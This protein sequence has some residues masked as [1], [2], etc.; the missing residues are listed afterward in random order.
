MIKIIYIALRF[1][2]KHCLFL[3][4][5][6]DSLPMEKEKKNVTLC[7]HRRWKHL[8]TCYECCY[9]GEVIPKGEPETEAIEHYTGSPDEDPQLSVGS[10]K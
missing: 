4:S 3:M 2:G 1:C 5:R 9:C 10:V 7:P 6:E 8:E